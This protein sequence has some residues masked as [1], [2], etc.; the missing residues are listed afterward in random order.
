MTTIN[1]SL[2]SK[3]KS[4]ADAL[5][6]QGY[7]AS[8]SDLVRMAIREMVGGSRYDTLIREAVN[9]H[10]KGRSIVL[11]NKKDIHNYILSKME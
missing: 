7:F 11:K 6:D 1:I 2:P 8:F 5:I 4:Q 10:R 3:L 9:D